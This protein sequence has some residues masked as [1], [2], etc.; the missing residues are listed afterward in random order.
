[1]E[2]ATPDAA[3]LASA[4]GHPSSDGA[5]EAGTPAPSETPP[6][7]KLESSVIAPVELVCRAG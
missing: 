6:T 7:A 3:I 1:M 5:K 2:A 4:H